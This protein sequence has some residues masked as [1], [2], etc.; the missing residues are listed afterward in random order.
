MTAHRRP[1]ETDPVIRLRLPEYKFKHSL[2]PRCMFIW[3]GKEWKTYSIA[4]L[5]TMAE[6]TGLPEA[7]KDMARKALAFAGKEKREERAE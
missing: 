7:Y 3:N 2:D 6:S 1:D 5:Q 4:V